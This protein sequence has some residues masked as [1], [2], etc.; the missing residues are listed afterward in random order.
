M[1]VILLLWNSAGAVRIR[2]CDI[3]TEKKNHFLYNRCRMFS[4]SVV[5]YTGYCQLV[6]S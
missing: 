3:I 6:G 2:Q 4:T 1:G 5:L